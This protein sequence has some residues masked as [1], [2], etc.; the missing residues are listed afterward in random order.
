MRQ[1][2][3]SM[4]PAAGHWGGVGSPQH[5]YLNNAV[6]G[7]EGEEYGALGTIP[8]VGPRLFFFW[9]FSAQHGPN[10]AWHAACDRIATSCNPPSTAPGSV[11]QCN[12][13]HRC[14]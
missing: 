1:M 6:G 3:A 14:L 9:S 5:G 4:A 8:E 7:G 10:Q 12:G 2:M 11:P 13:C